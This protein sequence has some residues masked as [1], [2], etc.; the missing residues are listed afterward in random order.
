MS[1]P[2]ETYEE[3]VEGSR[4]VELYTLSLGTSEWRYTS[5]DGD[6]VIGSDTWT[7]FPISRSPREQ[8]QEDQDQQVEVR[9]PGDAPLARQYI[10]SVP[11]EAATIIIE[12]VQILDGT[13]QRV[14]LLEGTVQSVT[15]EQGGEI[16]VLSIVTLQSAF[17]RTLPRDVY[18]AVCNHVLYD[19]R[20]KVPEVSFRVTQEVLAVSGNT[21]TINGLNAEVDNYYQ[22]GFVELTGAVRDFR[23]ILLQ[24]GNLVTVTL[25]FGTNPLGELVRVYAG[26]AHTADV[27][28]AKFDNLI[29][30]GGFPFVPTKNP[31]QTGLK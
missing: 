23:L 6:Y 9:L 25:P 7:P 8:S 12:R 13:Q 31:F 14:I 20:C 5:S 17:S 11:G 29:N 22:A 10:I 28:Q 18:S 19:E 26:C 1:P 24:V 4:P 27:C 3:S 15:Y 21:L 30:F 16:A 2:F